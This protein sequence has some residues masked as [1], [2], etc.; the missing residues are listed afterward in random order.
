M[1]TVTI[2]ARPDPATG[3]DPD[4]GIFVTETFA[5]LVLDLACMVTSEEYV[6]STIEPLINTQFVIRNYLTYPPYDI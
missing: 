3:T 5:T 2:T 6:W 1:Y 4:T